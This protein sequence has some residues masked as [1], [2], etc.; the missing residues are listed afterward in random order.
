M[1]T[2]PGL[3][4]AWWSERLGHQ[5]DVFCK[6]QWEDDV[7]LWLLDALLPRA[8]WQYTAWQQQDGWRH[9]FEAPRYS[10]ARTYTRPAIRVE[11][12]WL[13][14]AEVLMRREGKGATWTP[15]AGQKA[16]FTGRLATVGEAGLSSL[17]PATVIDLW[18]NW[19]KKP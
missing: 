4:A 16:A 6:V 18:H 8:A 14:F 13:A 2:S 9:L 1:A 12:D 10:W 3:A 11:P 19:Q 15:E 7:P 5:T 17:E